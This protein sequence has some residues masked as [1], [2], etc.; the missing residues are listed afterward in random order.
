MVQTENSPLVMANFTD[1]ARQ[2]LEKEGYIIHELTGLSVKDFEEAHRRAFG[3]W[4]NIYDD[5]RNLTSRISQVAINPENLF[6]PN[7]NQQDLETHKRMVSIFSYRLSRAIPGVRAILGEALDYADLAFVHLDK[8][9]ETLFG[10][11]YGY[12]YTRTATM[13]E[14]NNG[15]CVG[16]FGYGFGLGIEY[17]KPFERDSFVGVAPL[18]VPA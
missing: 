14:R 7:S 8:K 16:S 2:A 18:V 6:Y 9:G 1:E 12:R 13:I 10:K 4:G 17:L 15:A 11:K 3:S 5:P